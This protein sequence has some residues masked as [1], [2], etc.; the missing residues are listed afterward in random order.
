MIS[1]KRKFVTYNDQVSSGI[2][3]QKNVH[4]ITDYFELKIEKNIYIE[5]R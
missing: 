5:K 4:G 3:Q 2:Q 1:E